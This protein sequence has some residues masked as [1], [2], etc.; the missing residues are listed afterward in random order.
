[1]NVG[2]ESSLKGYRC[3]DDVIFDLDGTI[4]TDIGWALFEVLDGDLDAVHGVIG[5]YN[6][7][8]T[9]QLVR[10]DRAKRPCHL[11]G[12]F[13]DGATGAREWTLNDIV[14]TAILVRDVS[15]FA[16]FRATVVHPTL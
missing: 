11:Y 15:G 16:G 1:M 6:N 3:I 4:S 9:L 14:F 8:A 5:T 12:V 10:L 2:K 13:D 7:Y